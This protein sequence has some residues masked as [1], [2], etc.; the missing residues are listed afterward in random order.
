V[1]GGWLISHQGFAAA[2]W[3]AAACGLLAWLAASRAQVHR[4]TGAAA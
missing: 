3:A 4:Q 2:F 1:G